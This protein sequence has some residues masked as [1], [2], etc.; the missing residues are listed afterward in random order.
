MEKIV[1]KIDRQKLIIVLLL[2]FCLVLVGVI[3]FLLLSR[4]GARAPVSF[5]KQ[6]A[7]EIKTEIE[8]APEES[9]NIQPLSFNYLFGGVKLAGTIIKKTSAGSSFYCLKSKYPFNIYSS[10]K[11]SFE[12]DLKN[13]T[14]LQLIN[15]KG[16]ALKSYLN[17]E[18]EVEG[19]FMAAHT[20]HHH[21]DVLLE[22]KKIKPYEG[23]NEGTFIFCYR[24]GCFAFYYLLWHYWRYVCSS[25][26]ISII[27]EGFIYASP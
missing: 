16:L 5:K 4:K 6:A 20:A 26:S 14:E 25:G 8:Q 24:I 1:I 9:L 7:S 10:G 23:L 13:V 18:V 11:S 15:E 2:L 3:I 12:R 27:V 17:Q 21:T 19:D 22:L